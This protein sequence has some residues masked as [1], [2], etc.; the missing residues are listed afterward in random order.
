M[1]T[2][3]EGTFI[4]APVKV[5]ELN[6]ESMDF[7]KSIKPLYPELDHWSNAGFYFAWGAY[8]QDIYAIGWADWVRSRDNGFLAYCYITQLFP[9]FNFGGTGLYDSDVWDLGES[10]PWKKETEFKPDWVNI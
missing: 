4:T 6:N 1:F 8:S 2:F 7:I 5:S 3:N 10:Q 9:D